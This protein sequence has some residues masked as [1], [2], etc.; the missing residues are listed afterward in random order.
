MNRYIVQEESTSGHCCFQFTIEDT[1]QMDRRF[2]KPQAVCECFD[3]DAAKLVCAALNAAADQAA[4]V[5]VCVDCGT[6]TG[7][8]VELLAHFDTCQ[9]PREKKA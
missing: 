7:S 6:R 1:H 2:R 5:W 4:D 9:P 8:R 3:R